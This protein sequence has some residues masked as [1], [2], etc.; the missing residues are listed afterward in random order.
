MKQAT[1]NG[2][3]I[4][5]LVTNGEHAA[6]FLIEGDSEGHHCGR[7]VRIIWQTCGGLPEATRNGFLDGAPTSVATPASPVM[8]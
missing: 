8:T 6:Q 3:A 7:F 4:F 5:H 1:Q 2:N